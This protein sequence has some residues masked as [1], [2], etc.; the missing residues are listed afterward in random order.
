MDSVALHN[1]T[2]NIANF[3]IHSKYDGTN[4]VILGDGS[5]LSVSHISSLTLKSSQKI[6]I[7]SDT[8][9]VP[10]LCKNL[11]YVHHF[12]KQNNDFVEFHHFLF[13]VN[14]KIT[15]VIILR[16]VAMV[17]TPFQNSRLLPQK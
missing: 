16:R 13:F 12:T 17:F 8:L 3:S 14:E 7:L 11:I 5:S 9:C 4:E 2:S 1:I 10:N 15:G 6:F